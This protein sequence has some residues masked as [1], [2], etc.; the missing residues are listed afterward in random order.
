MRS[1]AAGAAAALRHLQPP[2]WST[3]SICIRAQLIVPRVALSRPA[4]VR[5]LTDICSVRAERGAEVQALVSASGAG[6]ALVPAPRRPARGWTHRTGFSFRFRAVIPS[7]AVLPFLVSLRLLLS[8]FSREDRP[9]G[10]VSV[11]STIPIDRVRFS[12][13]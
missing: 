4:V 2:P 5:F 1:G 12:G 10:S 8:R 9:P 7:L 3:S 13:R 11:L 6:G